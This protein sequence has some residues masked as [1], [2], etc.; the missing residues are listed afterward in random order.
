MSATTSHPSIHDPVLLACDQYCA[1]LWTG[2]SR[3]YLRR[4]ERLRLLTRDRSY[5]EDVRSR[6]DPNAEDTLHRLPSNLI[7]RSV[8]IADT[9]DLEEGATEVIDGDVFLLCT[10]GLSNEVHDL[11][12]GKAILPGNCRQ[13]SEALLEMALKRGGHD[14][15][16]TFVV[17]AEDLQRSDGT[18]PN[19]VL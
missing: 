15:I 14:S 11:E 16:S 4:D 7:T 17:R 1:C 18:E 12:I 2:D 9:L 3:N 13:A 19:P 5:V 8:G 6:R 10:D